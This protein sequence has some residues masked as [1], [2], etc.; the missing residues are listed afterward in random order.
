[1]AHGAGEVQA[2][3]IETDTRWRWWAGPY[4]LA[5]ILL[6]SVCLP[7]AQAQTIA[8]PSFESPALASGAYNT[9]IANWTI[10]NGGSAGVWAASTTYFQSIPDGKQIAYINGGSISQD[11]GQAQAGTPYILTVA[12]GNRGGGSLTISLGSCS[13]AINVSG[14]PSGTFADQTLTCASPGELLITITQT[15][16]QADFDNI[17]LATNPVQ[18]VTVSLSGNLSFSDSTI[19]YGSIVVSQMVAGVNNSLGSFPLDSSGNVS[20][21]VTISTNFQ[22]QLTLNFYLVDGTGKVLGSMQQQIPGVTFQLVHS[23]TGFHVVLKAGS[24]PVCTLAPGSTM[25]TMGP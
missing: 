5:M 11:A 24:C 23:I 10:S 17:R 14:I 21:S 15:G 25:G 6:C 4:A 9:S 1:M 19:P 8:N 22:D 13:Q 16:G 20:G 12:V 18:P 2:M 3:N 7:R